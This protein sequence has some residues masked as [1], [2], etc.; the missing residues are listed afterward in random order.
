MRNV[1]DKL[2]NFGFYE[3]ILVITK[4][5]GFF[6]NAANFTGFLMLKNLFRMGC[7]VINCY[8][9]CTIVNANNPRVDILYIPWINFAY[10]IS[11]SLLS[12][13]KVTKN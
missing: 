7:P 9:F 13:L 3:K 11:M 4:L 10:N 2:K 12:D 5:F 1:N 8:Y 6:Y